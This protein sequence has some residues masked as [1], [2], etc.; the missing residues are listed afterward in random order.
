MVTTVSTADELRDAVADG[1]PGSVIVARGGTYEMSGRW[2]INTGGDE[3]DQ[4][5]IRAANGE[6]P[7]IQFAAGQDNPTNDSGIKVNVPY[8]TVRGFEISDSGFKG[9]FAGSDGHDV[10]FEDLDV[11]HCNVWGIMN[12]G[13]DD[14]VFRNCDSHDNFD[15]QNNGQ[16]SDGI[17]M[18]GP[19]NNGLI[20]GCRAWNNGDDGYDLWVSENHTVRYC[21]AWNNGFGGTGNGNGFKLGSSRT[22]AGG[23]HLV[24]NC[25]SYGNQ[26]DNDSNSPGSGF[27]W[28]GEDD[29]PIEVYNCTAWDNGIDF[30]FDDTDHTLKNNVSYGGGVDIGGEVVEDANSWNLSASDPGFRSLDPDADGFLRL[31]EA[32]P[33]RGAGVAVP[34]EGLNDPPDL[35]AFQYDGTLR[36]EPAP[37]VTVD[38]EARLAASDA[39]RTAD[40][41]LQTGNDG[42]N[43]SGYINFT[44]DAGSVARWS[45]DVTAPGEYNY[46][47]RYANGGAGGRTAAMRLSGAETAIT[48][49]QTDG[50]ADW[51]AVTGAV[52]VPSGAT[53]LAIETTGEDAGNVDQILLQ[54]TGDDGT[55]GS[56]GGGSADGSGGTPS[57]G[58]TPYHGYSVP[59]EGQRDW[60]VPLNENFAAID[61]DIPVVDTE[62]AKDQYD[63]SPQTVY[64]AVDTGTIYVGDGSE[65]SQLGVLN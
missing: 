28:N 21:W 8:V 34:I 51:S 62:S 59:E 58:D 10:V 16:N 44:S 32:S 60:H 31:S 13:N 27:W 11:H 3:T 4:L 64:I 15:P 42:Y 19:A 7:H 12:N 39:E 48:F 17:N 52:E 30:A 18:T 20:E 65:W 43:G 40:A 46:R 25:V 23:G 1:G 26:V 35:G 61:R 29:N 5:V 2:N 24:H 33:Y 56:T 41:V 38:G 55:D 45:L 22:G 50:W 9:I 6:R 36:A 57:S 63:P 53:E 14:V 49:P 54:P 37:T 47:I